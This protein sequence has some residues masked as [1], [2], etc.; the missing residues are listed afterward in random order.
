M[1]QRLLWHRVKA[2]RRHLMMDM[3][4]LGLRML[5]VRTLEM[6]LQ[7]ARSERPV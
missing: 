1:R 3:L 7:Q 2:L 5:E 4:V 6:V